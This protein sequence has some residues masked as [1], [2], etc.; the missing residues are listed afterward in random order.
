[1]DDRLK[2]WLAIT[3]GAASIYSVD[4]ALQAGILALCLLLCLLGGARRFAVGYAVV[5]IAVGIG[6]KA[7]PGGNHAG[8]WT[9]VRIL[10]II[11][12]KF[13]PLFAMMIFLQATLRTTRLLH[14]MEKM[15]IPRRW[16]IPV[17]VCLRFMPSIDTEFRQIRHAMRVRGISITSGRLIHRPFETVGYMMVPLLVRSLTTGEELARAAIARGIEAPC[18]KT[19]IHDLS[20]RAIDYVIL[21]IW[22]TG[23]AVILYVDNAMFSIS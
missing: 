3:A 21:A 10:A 7:M 17:G 2:L 22:T 20:F 1:M 5:A 14:A 16:V 9:S 18:R 15:R 23:I 8:Q 11:V 4:M 19:C 13:G 6:L 12:I